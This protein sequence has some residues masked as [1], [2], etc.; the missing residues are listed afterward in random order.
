[1]H[2]DLLEQLIIA[3]SNSMHTDTYSQKLFLTYPL[4]SLTNRK[5]FQ[6]PTSLLPVSISQTSNFEQLLALHNA[7]QLISHQHHYSRYTYRLCTPFV[8]KDLPKNS[9]H[10]AVFQLCLKQGCR[11]QFSLKSDPQPFSIYSTL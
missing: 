6:A 10:Y 7:T 4:I 5:Y 2:P 8:V 9:S 11:I 3:S 1:M